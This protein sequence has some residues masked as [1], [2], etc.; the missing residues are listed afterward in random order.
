M[1]NTIKLELKCIIP[2]DRR[3]ELARE[4]SRYLQDRTQIEEDKKARMSEFSAQLKLV[5]AKINDLSGK[6]NSGTEFREVECEVLYNLPDNGD[7]TI[8]RTDTDPYEIVRVE[9][10]T[11]GEKQLEMFE[12]EPEPSIGPGLYQC[13]VELK[14]DK[15]MLHHKVGQKIEILLVD[16]T[17]D[18]PFVHCR[19]PSQRQEFDM[20]L[21]HIIK[22][23]KKLKEK[24][25]V[26][27][28]KDPKKPRK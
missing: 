25:N 1:S 13:S 4:L 6:V 20:G 2:E 23:Y 17:K 10:M 9:E 18:V 26:K 14:D 27:K 21:E 8:L 22:H 16:L 5:I 28:N 15:A 19:I 11:E 7:K 3:N 24:K 12:D